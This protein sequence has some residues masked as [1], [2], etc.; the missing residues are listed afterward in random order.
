VSLPDSVTA[1]RDAVTLLSGTL[2]SYLV[3]EEHECVAFSAGCPVVTFTSI[4]GATRSV[5]LCMQI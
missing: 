1:V 4:E 5:N 2:L 3:Y